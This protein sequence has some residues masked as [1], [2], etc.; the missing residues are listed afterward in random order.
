MRSFSRDLAPIDDDH[1]RTTGVAAYDFLY[2]GGE[3]QVPG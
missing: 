1:P 2:G 3:G